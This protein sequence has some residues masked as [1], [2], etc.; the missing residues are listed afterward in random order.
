M[1][2]V[3]MKPLATIGRATQVARLFAGDR[4]GATSI[5]YGLIAAF[6]GL[7]LVAVMG[8]VGAEVTR[9]FE[10]VISLFP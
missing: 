5:E 4:S 10:K 8:T 3:V 2:T 1:N 9:L 6:M 7:S